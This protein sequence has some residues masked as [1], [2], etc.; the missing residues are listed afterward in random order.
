MASRKFLLVELVSGEDRHHGTVMHLRAIGVQFNWTLNQEVVFSAAPIGK[1]LRKL[2]Y[3]Q[4]LLEEM[5]HRD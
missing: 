3:S 1:P 2:S 5:C 4:L